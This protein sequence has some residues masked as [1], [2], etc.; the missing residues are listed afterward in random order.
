MPQGSCSGANLFTCYCSLIKDETDN[1]ITL[2][3]FADDHSIC[4]NFKA[5]IKVQEHKIKTDLEEA[6]T[7]LKHWMDTM[8][9]KLSPNKTEYILFGPWQQLKKTSSEPLDA[10]GDPIAVSDAVR[11]LGRFLDQHLNF[12]KHINEK[13]KR[14][15]ANI[16]KIHAGCKYLTVQS[17]TTLVLMLCITYLDYANA[18]LYGLPSS[19]LRKYQTIQNSCTKLILNKDRY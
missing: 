2:T 17:C 6:F 3:A 1:S 5:G 10:H 9:L 19:T 16:I 4:N 14:A 7:Q 18:M 12:K 15:M 8:H 11:Y 13:A